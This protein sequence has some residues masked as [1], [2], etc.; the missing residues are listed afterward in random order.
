MAENWS[1]S[2]AACGQVCAELGWQIVRCGRCCAQMVLGAAWLSCGLGDRG[3][4][5][6][7]GGME[8]TDLIDV[9]LAYWL[10]LVGWR[11]V[12]M[13]VGAIA[14]LAVQNGD[15]CLRR[16]GSCVDLSWHSNHVFK[17]EGVA[18]QA[19]TRVCTG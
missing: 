12:L 2:V 19:C 10:V 17:L 13:R 4:R 11:V 1:T 16:A 7:L 9:T 8:V 15:R 6:D 3:C 14:V 18:C 5:L